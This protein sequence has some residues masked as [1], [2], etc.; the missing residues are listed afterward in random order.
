MKF[1]KRGQCS[2]ASGTNWKYE[3]RGNMSI[4]SQTG[5]VP[6]LLVIKK[7]IKLLESK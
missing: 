6:S 4:F 2:I 7:C 5:K 3:R 1:E